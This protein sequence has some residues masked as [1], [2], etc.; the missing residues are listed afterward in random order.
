[1][2]GVSAGLIYATYNTV[3]LLLVVLATLLTVRMLLP[4][5]SPWKRLLIFVLAVVF[6]SPPDVRVSIALL[7]YAGFLRMT[8]GLLHTP[9]RTFWYSLAA[10]LIVLLTFLSSA[11]TGLYSGAA[12]VLCTM[13][14]AIGN[15]KNAIAQTRL[16]AYTALTVLCFAILMI[17]TNAV[18]RSPLDFGYWKSSMAIATGYRWFEATAMT[19]ADKWRLLETLGLLIAALAAAWRWCDN[20]A[21]SWTQRSEFLLSG[22]L[23]AL[24]MMQSGLVRSDA[25][26][27]MIGMYPALFLSG[28]IL[29]AAGTPS[30]GGRAFFWSWS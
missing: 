4:D 18:M 14:F 3:P 17:A 10:A 19:K 28:A 6:W 9:R 11:D 30:P 23:L 13:A 7:A 8:A 20:S 5:A 25:G 12:F 22:G 16:L 15:R 21:R 24:L 26:H 27:V 29:I 1:M 2:L